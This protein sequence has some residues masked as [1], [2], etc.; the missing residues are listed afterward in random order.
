MTWFCKNCNENPDIDL[1]ELFFY[2]L[3]IDI[4]ISLLIISTSEVSIK[5]ASIFLT[6]IQR[7]QPS[8]TSLQWLL[9]FLLR[10]SASLA[11]AEHVRT[12]CPFTFAQDTTVLPAPFLPVLHHYDERKQPNWLQIAD[13]L[14]SVRWWGGWWWVGWGGGLEGGL[15][16]RLL[17]VWDWRANCTVHFPAN[18]CTTSRPSP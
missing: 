6:L 15:P 5:V 12:V 3:F 4:G 8:S 1:I 2:I 13:E 18:A 7:V 17:Y 14:I 9:F 10:M 11:D 16:R